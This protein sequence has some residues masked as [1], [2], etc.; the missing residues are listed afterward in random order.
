MGRDI[1]KDLSSTIEGRERKD[2]SQA[3]E[4]DPLL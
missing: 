1:L 2:L 4:E 3:G